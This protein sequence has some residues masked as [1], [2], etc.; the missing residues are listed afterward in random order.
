MKD[1][2]YKQLEILEEDM[3][4][5]LKV[6]IESV[7]TQASIMEEFELEEMP[8]EYAQ[9]LIDMSEKYPEYNELVDNLVDAMGFHVEFF[10]DSP[11]D[12]EIEPPEL[13]N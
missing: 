12:I 11:L 13:P 4:H 9:N 8:I 2:G 3:P 5:D 10:D 1:K 7:V 6:A